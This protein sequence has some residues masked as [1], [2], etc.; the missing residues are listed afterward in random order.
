[1]LSGLRGLLVY[2]GARPIVRCQL[3]R[4]RPGRSYLESSSAVASGR[5]KCASLR[6]C[7]C[8]GLSNRGRLMP[9]HRRVSATSHRRF[10]VWLA[11]Q[12][13]LHFPVLCKRCV[14]CFE[15]AERGRP[16]AC[17]HGVSSV[18]RAPA[19]RALLRWLPP[20]VA[21][22]VRIKAQGHCTA[23]RTTAHLAAATRRDGLRTLPHTPP[24]PKQPRSTCCQRHPPL[25]HPSR[26]WGHR[27]TTA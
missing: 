1:M 5:R 3:I 2:S 27:S 11:G 20:P 4:T 18:H 9:V 21:V 19:G 6:D 15:R 22:S 10:S 24:S 8:S 12:L 17:A 16:V 25:C 23:A 26:D 7:W 13:L 14:F